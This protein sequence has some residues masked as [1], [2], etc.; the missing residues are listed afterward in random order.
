MYKHHFKI[1]IIIFFCFL[2]TLLVVIGQALSPRSIDLHKGEE[3]IRILGD[4]SYDYSGCCVSS[5]DINGDGY[6]DVIIGAP[7]AYPP[8][9]K[10]AGKTFVIF[11]SAEPITNVDL[12][13]T[14]ADMT[15]YGDDRYDNSGRSVSSGDV[16]DDG[17]DDV[18]IG[19]R[20]ADPAG[21]NEAGETYVI[22]GSAAPP[23]T[24]D[25]N[26]VSADMTIYG[27]DAGDW[28]GYSVSSGDVN[29]DG[30]ADVI[31]GAPWADHPSRIYSF[32]VG[33]TYVIFGSAAPPTTVDLNST[34]AD[35][36]IYGDDDD[37]RS[38]YSV[39]SG[40][41]NGDGYDDVIIGAYFAS[42]K[43]GGNAGQTYVIFGCNEPPA[44]IDLDSVSADMTIYADDGGDESGRSVSSGDINGDG[45]DDVII[46]AYNA[47]QPGNPYAGETY[48]IFGSAAPPAT[49]DLDSVSADMTILGDYIYDWSGRSVSSGDI[50]GDGFDDVIIGAPDAGS[51]GS[52]GAGKTYVIFGSS[53]PP[54]AI[55]LDS[56]SADITIYGDDGESHS[57]WSV[58]S[59]DINGDG[60]ADVI[61][62][63]PTAD[64]A[65]GSKAGET[66]VILGS[67]LPIECD[68]TGTD[69]SDWEKVG[70]GRAIVRDGQ[71]IL[72]RTSSRFRLFPK[73]ALASKCDIETQLIRK[74]G[75]A[76]RVS[77]S[78]FFSYLDK[79]NY[80]ELKMLLL[81]VGKRIKGKWILRHKKNGFWVEKQVIKD[82]I[83]RTQQYQIKIE[84]RTDQ[85]RVLVDGVEKFNITPGEKPA[86]GKIALSSAGP[87][88][89][90]FDD[91]KIY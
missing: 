36:T 77:S 70:P 76:S 23:A 75:R 88:Q 12:S 87:G 44:T 38:G 2:A 74:G 11:G 84:V 64:P 3:N 80:W 21:G 40:D 54:A 60:C 72:R 19:A 49:V 73:G 17:F 10:E 7:S 1:I 33:T 8:G 14:S 91:L 13:S 5:G 46:G 9:G 62:G 28:S 43:G 50:N 52:N 59:G 89:S 82:D 35:M 39:S 57:G 4:D 79:R 69:I 42:P 27:D 61:I 47:D 20:Y 31:I 58:S 65:G 67:G 48:V 6:A 78:I 71:L 37:D 34:S 45:F 81:P 29:G 53:A 24:V 86:W 22:F 41:I 55:D 83:Y 32:K 63:A 90:F 30:Y 26:S 56:V 18:I 51:E 16:N 66:Y 15:I 25:L 85:I 68:F